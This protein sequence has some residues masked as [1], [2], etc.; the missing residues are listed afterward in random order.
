MSKGYYNKDEL[1]RQLEIENIYDLVAELGGEPEYASFGLTATT[2]CHNRPG[3]GSRKLYYYSNSGLFR[4][5]T[6]CGESFDAF[7]LVIKARKIQ[8]NED[9][10][11]YD[12][13][14][15]IAGYFGFAEAEKPEEENNLLKDWELFKRYDYNIPNFNSVGYQLKE[16]DAGILDRFIYPRILSWEEEGI[17]YQTC[18]NNRIGYYPGQEQITIP[19][20]DIDGRLVGIRGRYLGAEEASRFGKYR[21]LKI[22]QTL[23]THPL[24]MN[25]YN[26]NNSKDAIQRTKTAIIYESEKSTLMHSSYFGTENDISV[27]CCGSSISSQQVELLKSLG[28]REIIIAF[29]RDFLAI[30]DE[31]FIRLKRKIQGIYK[32]YNNEVKITAIFDKH[33]ITGYKNSPIDQGIEKFKILLNERI[34]E[35]E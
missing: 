17:S 27:A 23:Y 11:L 14:A 28:V 13:M 24:S 35:F 7:Q 32:K 25:L 22:G 18:Q 20:F 2:I 16:Y 10:E 12:A 15:Y 19:H 8:W 30:G 33:M 4:C 29:D 3:E 31:E 34:R 6:A 5:F 21:P 1:R 26:L 9:W